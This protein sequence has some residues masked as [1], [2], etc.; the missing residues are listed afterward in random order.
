MM[1]GPSLFYTSLLL[2][3]TVGFTSVYAQPPDSL[4]MKI[5]ADFDQ[6]QSVCSL[7]D[8]FVFTGHL[9]DPVTD[10]DTYIARV[11]DLGELEWVRSSGENGDDKAY[12]ICT[13]AD[14]GFIAAGSSVPTTSNYDAYL[15]KVSASGQLQ[16]THTYGGSPYNQTAYSVVQRDNG[17]YAVAGKAQNPSTPETDVVIYFTDSFGNLEFTSTISFGYYDD[18]ARSICR[19]PTGFV[20]A[21][22]RGVSPSYW[23]AL[24]L[25]LRV[26]NSGGLIWSKTYGTGHLLDV[27][28][29]TDGGLIA[30][31]N[32]ADPTRGYVV[33]TDYSGNLIWDLTI[34][35]LS[36]AAGVVETEDGGF[37]F[38]GRKNYDNN[39]YLLKTDTDGTLEWL[40]VY[41]TSE[42][43]LPFSLDSTIDGGFVICG[44]AGG[45]G[46]FLLKVGSLVGFSH[47]SDLI[48]SSDVRILSICPAPLRTLTT[49]E[50]LTSDAPASL[51]A[52]D[53]TGCE[54]AVLHEGALSG[55]PYSVSWDGTNSNGENLPNGVYLIH[56]Y[57]GVHS[58]VTKIVI[59]R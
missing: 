37:V 33:R 57:S 47:E 31:G 35:E 20:L 6:A 55:T 19:V 45:A 48:P 3:V 22:W 59:L 27:I 23:A 56:L 17:G 10:Y 32:L 42:Y 54:V 5:Y 7:D 53:I 49:I 39:I 15:M 34:P 13:T 40:T 36:T 11:D 1:K 9:T 21:G 2:A 24:A 4:W 30:C 43:A 58:D 26:N 16:W 12:S 52:Y 25:L 50:L 44:S 41:C 8:G 51:V 14:G 29:T 18:V 28:E 46:E 38:V